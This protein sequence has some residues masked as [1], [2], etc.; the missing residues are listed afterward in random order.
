MVKL[1]II[2]GLAGSLEDDDRADDTKLTGSVLN[3]FG[4][5]EGRVHGCTSIM[6]A[7]TKI[8]PA[9]SSYTPSMA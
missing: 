6:K 2:V 3:S 9:F 4:W 5:P 7:R 1:L 8:A